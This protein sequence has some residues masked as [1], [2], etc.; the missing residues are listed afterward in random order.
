MLEYDLPNGGILRISDEVLS[1]FF[2]SRQRTC[3]H[4]ESGGI[5]V[6]R[7]FENLTVIDKVSTP[8][9]SKDRRGLFFFHR[10]KGRAQS[11]INEVFVES[12]GE[13][14]YIGEW[15]SHPQKNP[16]PS[17]KDRL[18]IKRAFKK[19]QLRLDY[20][21]CIIVGSLDKVGNI[22]VGYQDRNG[23]SL[24]KRRLIVP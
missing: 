12:N 8:D 16:E 20:L 6:G 14:T 23:M 24:S 19:S 5:L 4:L 13:R 1:V 22:W 15:H 18:E 17:W 11:I 21:I 10:H 9:D 7:I 2:R 3:L